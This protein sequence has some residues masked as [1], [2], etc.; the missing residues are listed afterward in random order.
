MK[1]VLE[2]CPAAGAQQGC[3]VLD[4]TTRVFYMFEGIVGRH[5]IEGAQGLDVVTGNI[6]LP[7]EPALAIGSFVNA[8]PRVDADDVGS[9]YILQGGAV[10]AISA[11]DLK[12]S[13]AAETVGRYRKARR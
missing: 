11:P 6:E 1:V 12:D 5:D 8:G 4:G 3:D 7:E 2:E 10:F 13:F 9:E